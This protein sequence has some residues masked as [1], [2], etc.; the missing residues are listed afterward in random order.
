MTHLSWAAMQAALQKGM[1]LEDATKVATTN[2]QTPTE[3]RLEYGQI[4]ARANELMS[5]KYHQPLV[6]DTKGGVIVIRY[7][8]E[9]SWP[10]GNNP[11]KAKAEAARQFIEKESYQI[12]LTPPDQEIRWVSFSFL[13]ITSNHTQILIAHHI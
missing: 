11:K 6:F 13:L 10:I 1:T 5:K 2:E 8:E 9:Y 12:T 3:T 4:I 7:H